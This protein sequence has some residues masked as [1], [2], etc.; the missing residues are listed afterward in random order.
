MKRTSLIVVISLLQSGLIAA[1]A[2]TA[3]SKSVTANT[4][5]TKFSNPQSY[6]LGRGDMIVWPYA[7]ESGGIIGDTYW[8]P[9]WSRTTILLYE[10]ERLVEDYL[11]RLDVHK[12]ELEFKLEKEI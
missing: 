12:S 4:I 8:D 7:P 9:H 6:N 5:L 2:Q 3:L 10:H 11:T 1:V